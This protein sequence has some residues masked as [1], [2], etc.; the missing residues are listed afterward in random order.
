MFGE[1]TVNNMINIYINNSQI[2]QKDKVKYLG[3]VIDKNLK[4]KP[5]ILIDKSTTRLSKSVEMLYHLQKYLSI[6]NLKLVYHALIKS[7][8]QYG[9][10]L[11][12]NANQL[13]LK[14]L[15]KMHDRAIRYIT[16]QPY[17]TRLNNVYAFSKLLKV[18]ELHRYSAIKFMFRLYNDS[19]FKDKIPLVNKIYT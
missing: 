1:K 18:N 5:H 8:L 9:I 17:R 16:M 14:N 15:N 2:C 6:N 19:E 4:W 10:V 11:W 3:G 12:R 13:A 7:R